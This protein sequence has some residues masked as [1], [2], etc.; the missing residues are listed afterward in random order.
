MATSSLLI[1][2]TSS[3]PVCSFFSFRLTRI[4]IL[5]CLDAQLTKICH[6]SLVIYDDI[7]GS[8]MQRE[9]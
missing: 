5:V 3:G 4:L 9:E 6:L 2:L 7:D 8:V 1:I